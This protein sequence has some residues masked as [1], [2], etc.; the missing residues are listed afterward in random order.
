MQQLAKNQMI[1]MAAKIKQSMQ[2]IRAAANPQ[3][4]LNMM[5]M[6]NPNMKQVM[7]IIQQYGG[8]PMKALEE[9]SKQF[10]MTSDDVLNMLK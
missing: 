4:A 1:Q 6:N 8:D 2:T 9:T 10:G 3:A 5:I 7:E